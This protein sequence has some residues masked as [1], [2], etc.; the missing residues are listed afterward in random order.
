M[1]EGVGFGLVCPKSA[2][3]DGDK[4]STRSDCFCHFCGK[5]SYSATRSHLNPILILNAQLSRITRMNLDKRLRMHLTN[6]LNPTRTS[7]SM[8]VTIEPTRGQDKGIL[9]IR[10]FRQTS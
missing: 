2:P 5:P 1:G 6:L 9:L 10:G 8:P 3:V 7:L 4:H